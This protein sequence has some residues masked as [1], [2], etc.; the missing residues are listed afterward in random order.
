MGQSRSQCTQ[1]LETAVC[2]TPKMYIAID[3]ENGTDLATRMDLAMQQMR[4]GIKAGQEETALKLARSGRRVGR[5]TRTSFPSA[6][7]NGVEQ[8]A[9][10]SISQLKK[11]REWMPYPVQKM[12]SSK[13]SFPQEVANQAGGS[14]RG[15]LGPV[16]V[17]EYDLAD[18][19]D[20]ERWIEKEERAAKCY[21][22]TRA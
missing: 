13:V 3:A 17:E 15:R 5:E 21:A 22:K 19:S 6:R 20:D 1:H 8:A 9:S 18:D 14:L 2:L 10:S 11:E 16:H 12:Q 7:S 4:E